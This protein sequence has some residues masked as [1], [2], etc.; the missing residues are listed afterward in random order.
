VIRER[1]HSRSFVW[2]SV[3]AALAL[4][5]IWQLAA[6]AG[7][8]SDPT[9][10][11]RLGHGSVVVDSALLVFRE[12]LESILVLA[13]ITA[14]M[15]GANRSQ[16]RP[17]AA[18]AAGGLAAGAAT[19]FLAIWVIG[20]FGN[21]GLGVQAATGLL[22]VAVLLVVMNW[23]FHKVYWTGWI[24]HHNRRRKRLTASHQGRR[25]LLLGLAA[26]GFTSVYREGFEIVLF[27][28]NMRITYGAATVLEGVAIGLALTAMVGVV[29]FRLQRKL[30]YRRMLV[31]TGVTIGLVLIVMVGESVQEMQLAGWLPTTP[32]GLPISDSLG[33]W[34]AIFPTAE[35][36]IA[37]VLAASLVIGSYA[38]AQELRVRRP[39]RRGEPEAVR[40]S[41]PPAPAGIPAAG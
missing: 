21:P 19:W 39:R 36:L 9:A 37:Q 17:V 27:L 20:M 31:A 18:G 25:T 14:S 16:R 35:G 34:F 13:A 10:D 33:L 1:V 38:V 6:G 29:T 40:A 5:V 24:S 32:V 12:G 7:S 3:G 4:L 23:F 11:H 2:V 8:V 41:A 15:L 22:A 28:Q 26:L 30:P